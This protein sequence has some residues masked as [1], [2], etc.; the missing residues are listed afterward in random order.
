MCC[1]NEE[2]RPQGGP[3]CRENR[4][5]PTYATMRGM[6][7]APWDTGLFVHDGPVRTLIA[8]GGWLAFAVYFYLCQRI[9]RENGYYLPFAGAR[10]CAHT[11]SDMGGVTAAEVWRSLTACFAADLFSGAVFRT[12]GVLTG[13][14][15]QRRYAR[16]LSHCRAPAV[17]RDIW[18]LDAKES[19]RLCP[20]L[21]WT[22]DAPSFSAPG[23][24]EGGGV[25][26]G[27]RE[28]EGDKDNTHTEGRAGARGP[29]G[30]NTAGET[31]GGA[32]PDME[33][34]LASAETAAVPD[35]VLLREEAAAFLRFNAER[36][37][38]CL[39]DW[40]DKWRLWLKRA[41]Y[42][43]YGRGA[44]DAG[45]PPGAGS[46]KCKTAP[47]SAPSYDFDDFVQAALLRTYG[48]DLP[49]VTCPLPDRET[50]RP[51]GAGERNG[52]E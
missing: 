15:V 19:R 52:A 5:W 47:P 31:A 16:Y 10:D 27:E 9:G 7:W 37:W 42:L 50:D 39:P 29:A 8:S 36:S 3:V 43:R 25:R 41:P 2:K 21:A 35:T 11:A 13:A 44:A 18:L 4:T 24:G 12:H 38:D 46:R 30:K 17:R 34:L 32:A 26:E 51:G 33:A 28:K 40:E 48:D 1:E 20:D 49:G 45:S 22:E 6:P 23:K 14:E